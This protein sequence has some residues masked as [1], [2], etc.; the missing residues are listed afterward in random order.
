MLQ[1]K[2]FKLLTN[3][4]AARERRLRRAFGGQKVREILV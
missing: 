2:L 1:V 3:F 4:G